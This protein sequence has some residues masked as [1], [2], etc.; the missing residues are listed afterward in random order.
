M[1]IFVLNSGKGNLGKFDSRSKEGIFVKYFTLSK[2]YRI[3][4]KWK[5]VIEESMHVMFDKSNESSLSKC[6]FDKEENKSK[7]QY[8]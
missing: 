6:Q 7:D 2:T 8:A 4:N 3:Y 1:P 5:L